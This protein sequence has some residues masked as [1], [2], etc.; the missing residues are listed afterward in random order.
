M[1]ALDTMIARLRRHAR[2]AALFAGAL[3]LIPF[4]SYADLQRHVV[5]GTIVKSVSLG[6]FIVGDNDDNGYISWQIAALK[7]TP[8]TLPTVYLLGG[9]STRE[10]IPSTA[11]LTTALNSR[12][13]NRAKVMM[14]AS[15]VQDYPRALAIIDNLPKAKGGVIVIGVHHT[16]FASPRSSATD[17]L[18]GIDLLMKSPALRDF[19]AARLG[20]HP[21]T[22]LREGLAVY[23][24]EYRRVRGAEPFRGAPITYHM[25]RYS[26]AHH[27]SDAAKRSR[28]KY[29]L[30]GKGA[31][32]G[33]F[34]TYFNF[35]AACLTE[36]V[37]LARAKGFE[38]LLMECPQNAE[39]VKG[40]FDRYKD[41]Y[42]PLCQKLV[43][44]QGAHYVDINETA[45]LV[46]ADFRDLYHLVEPGRAKWQPKL[47]DALAAIFV[48]HL[49]IP[50]ESPSPSPSPSPS[51][52]TPAVASG[53]ASSSVRLA[54]LLDLVAATL[55]SPAP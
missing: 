54:G 43:D 28:L 25:H 5:D 31:P 32:G 22:N 4:G 17:E 9:S 55:A 48:D 3:V 21:S 12:Q 19:V 33:P 51:G 49:P 42:R 50:G 1:K 44:E 26:D 29:W 14:L 37:K 11:S 53:S 24:D 20:G 46:D 6:R 27:W 30:T 8:P 36:A 13:P 7:Q 52:S 39:F 40:A 38:V 16:G 15:S 18:K 10:C 45:G 35:N 41:K 23:L 47:A 2:S 34:D